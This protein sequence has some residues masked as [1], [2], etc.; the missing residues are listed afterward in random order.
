[1]K[2]LPLGQCAAVLADCSLGEQQRMTKVVPDLGVSSTAK[3]RSLWP[4]RIVEGS[5]AHELC[6]LGP[7]TGVL[8]ATSDTNCFDTPPIKPDSFEAGGCGTVGEYG[9]PIEYA[10]QTVHEQART[11][12]Y[13]SIGL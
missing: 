11:L 13:N 7:I 3:A 9:R 1:V 8:V 4:R 2:G 10:I 5:M 6:A 12:D